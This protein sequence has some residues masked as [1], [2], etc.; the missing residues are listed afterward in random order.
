MLKNI[1]YTILFTLICWGGYQLSYPSNTPPDLFYDGLFLENT[2]EHI[3]YMT[4]GPRGVGQYYHDDTQRYL[5]RKLNAMGFQV[6]RQKSVAFNPKSRN[7]APIRNIIAKYPGSDPDAKD[8]L[9]LAHY[10]AAVYSGTGAGDDASGV[11]VILETINAFIKTQAKPKNNLLVV[12]TDAEEIGLLGAHAFINEQLNNHD[13]GLIINLEARG[14]S[15]PGMMW[16]ET[17]GGNR[18]MIE[19]FQAAAVPMPVTTS[20]TYEIYKMLPNDTDLTPFN[21]IGQINGFNL[22]FIDD[23][24]NYHTQLD[25]LSRLSLNT[26]AHQSIQTLALLRHFA[27]ADLSDMK[28]AESLVYFSLP[29]VGIIAYPTWLNWLI[30]GFIGLVT[31]LLFMQA[32]KKQLLPAKHLLMAFIWLLSAA[33]LAYLGC[34]LLLLLVAAVDPASKDILQGFSYQGHLIMAVS[35]IGSCLIAMTVLGRSKA[36]SGSFISIAVS[37]L[38]LI[39]VVYYLP[40]SGLLLLPVLTATILLLFQ[41]HREKWA[42]QLAPIVAVVNFILA[43]TL[44]VNLPIALGLSALP[45]TAVILTWVLSLSWPVISPVK[46]ISLLLILLLLAA[47]ALAYHLNKNPSMTSTQPH[48]TS[49]SY[50]YDADKQQAY[51]F[52]YDRHQSEWH[53]GLFEQRLNNQET[54]AFRQH[55]RKPVRQLSRAVETIELMPTTV[56]VTKPLLRPNSA[57]L[58]VDIQANNNTDIIE[59]YPQQDITITTISIDGRKAVLTEPLV[60]GA[61]NRM[62]R[63]YFNGKKN[64]RITLETSENKPFVWQVQSISNDLLKQPEFALDNRPENQ[65]PK[66]FI[67]SDNVVVVQ[68][69]AFGSD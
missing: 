40:G 1:L 67:Q 5:V 18:A 16:P 62:L 66:P 2:L 45:I 37:L 42:E 36:L 39:P 46:R 41:V 21:Q 60:I 20:L 52:H 59:I 27:Q 54:L 23:H 63:Y 32:R 17:V 38:L 47:L 61:G 24:F 57:E 9:L 35:L 65:I 3:E 6:S 4:R 22:A 55:Y 19:A 8:L 33:G 34:W 26:L 11:A 68:S 58:L 29:N 10:D 28:S 15:G 7:A 56:T 48:P 51:Y 14:S 69:V 43:G 31:F 49:L 50:L 53:Q 25:T 30:V 13:V 44:L 64:I 12:F